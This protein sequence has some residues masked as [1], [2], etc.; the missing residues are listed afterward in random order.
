MLGDAEYDE[1]WKAKL[2]WYR[3][4]GVLLDEEGGGK[5][6]TLLTSNETEGIDHD[7]IERLIKKI[8]GGE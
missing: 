2:E 5:N 8:K 1:K 3:K 4:N 7:Q 6:G